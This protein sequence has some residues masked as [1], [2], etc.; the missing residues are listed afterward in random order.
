M[1]AAPAQPA[2]FRELAPADPPRAR[3]PGRRGRGATPV[4]ERVVML[5]RDNR[6]G[7]R[8]LTFRYR[9]LLAWSDAQRAGVERLLVEYFARLGGF[10]V[11]NDAIVKAWIALLD[12][13]SEAEIRWAIDAKVKSLRGADPSET[14]YKRQFLGT[15]SGF[16]EKGCGY[17]LEQSDAYQEHRRQQAQAQRDRAACDT[18]ARLDRLINPQPGAAD[19]RRAAQQTRQAADAAFWLRLSAN[20]QRIAI[21]A[22]RAQLMQQA[23]N[24][25]W[26]P[27]APQADALRRALAIDYAKQHWPP[28]ESSA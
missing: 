27:D 3:I 1:S 18:A 11:A 16:A 6:A 7:R 24:Y 15:P 28:K 21:G 13:F 23:A 26:D 4:Y 25:G 8:K 5:D 17:W 2:L 14:D 9:P 22:T 12:D 19:R 20:R 10:R